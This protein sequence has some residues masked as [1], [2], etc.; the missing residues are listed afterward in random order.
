[1]ISH[2]NILGCWRP[3]QPITEKGEAGSETAL[4]VD[5]EPI[6]PVASQNLDCVLVQQPRMENG[7]LVIV[8]KM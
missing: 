7:R 4:T 1:M 5:G 6:I 8:M 3:L 2:Y